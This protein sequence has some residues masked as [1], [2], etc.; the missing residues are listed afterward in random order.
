MIKTFGFADF[1]VML[2]TRPDKYVGSVEAWDMATDILK[3]TLEREKIPYDV[4]EGGGAFYGPKIDIKLVD[5]LGRGWQGPT[6]QVDFN[7]PQRFDVNYT[8]EDGTEKQVAMVHRVVLAQWNGLWLRSSK[9]R[10]RVPGLAVTRP[11][12]GHSHRRPAHRICQ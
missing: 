7:L 6:I 1:Q 5:A 2:S 8:A 4:D 11:G 10:R 9:L 12:R 3:R